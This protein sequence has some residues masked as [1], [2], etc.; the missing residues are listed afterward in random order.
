MTSFIGWAVPKIFQTFGLAGLSND[1]RDTMSLASEVAGTQISWTGIWLIVFIFSVC[2]LIYFNYA[3]IHRWFQL[4]NQR[5][6]FDMSLWDASLAL[7]K[8]MKNFTGVDCALSDAVKLIY[9]AAAKGNIKIGGRVD[10]SEKIKPINKKAIRFA[11]AHGLINE[12]DS[13]NFMERFG[14]TL[15]L[16]VTKSEIKKHWRLE[17]LS[18]EGE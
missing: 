10:L 17:G 16:R 2:F 14:T 6:A 15:D 8:E 3:L 11:I 13:E 7:S 5:N 9:S 4:Q 1:M 12:I 18:L